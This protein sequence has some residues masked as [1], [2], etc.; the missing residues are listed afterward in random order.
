[1]TMCLP[2]ANLDG[3]MES[4]QLCSQQNV[5]GCECNMLL[6]LTEDS[7]CQCI[8]NFPDS[9][10]VYAQTAFDNPVL[11]KLHKPEVSV[12]WCNTY[13]AE[14]TFYSIQK[15]ADVVEKIA[16]VLHPSY[17]ADNDLGNAYCES[18]TFLMESLKT[19]RFPRYRFEIDK[20]QFDKLNLVYSENSCPV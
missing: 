4:V 13:W 17:E 6:P 10:M 2:T 7:M 12:H 1:M 14:W 20:S 3:R 16:G 18:S 15:Y 19:M 5:A 9:L 8:R 11:S